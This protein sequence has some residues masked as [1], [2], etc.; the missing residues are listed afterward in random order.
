MLGKESEFKTDGYAVIDEFLTAGQCSEI[1]AQ[2]ASY[3]ENHEV[4]EVYRPFRERSLHYFVINGE[5][6]EGHFPQIWQL[7]E[8]VGELATQISGQDLVPLS[9]KM[10]AVNINIVRPGGEYRWH[11]DRNAVT[12]L[13]YLNGVEGG[14]IELY[15]NYRMAIGSQKF[16]FGQK[17]LDGILQQRWVRDVFGRKI[18]EQPRGGMMLIMKGDQCLH[19]VRPVTGDRE[20]INVIMSYDKLGAQFS[21][22]KGLDSY[23][24]TTE[25]QASSDPNYI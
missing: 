14:E 18:S 8:E 25:K 2:I 23:L 20:R 10:P 19:S 13:L 21:V 17:L 24:Y 15:P 12:A 1:L 9:N 3:R 6:I 4:V 11:Y 7:Y 22:E 16:T 5:L